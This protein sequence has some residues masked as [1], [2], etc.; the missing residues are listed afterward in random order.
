MAGLLTWYLNVICVVSMTLI[1]LSIYYIKGTMT[2][3]K[4]KL[5]G[6]TFTEEK[7]KADKEEDI[8][9][10]ESVQ[11]IIILFYAGSNWLVAIFRDVIQWE[12]PLK[13]GAI[14][15]AFI[16]A[17]AITQFMGDR[18]LLWTCFFGCFFVPKLIMRRSKR[19]DEK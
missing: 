3:I 10:E 9:S 19:H 18:G 6:P 1:C 4:C 5:K 16:T 12:R 15:F 8:L 14:T 7:R 17:S 13:C 2:I 11:R